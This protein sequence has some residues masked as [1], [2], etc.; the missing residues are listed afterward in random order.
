MPV[1]TV[2][3]TFEF[4]TPCRYCLLQLPQRSKRS[5]PVDFHKNCGHESVVFFKTR[6]G[7]IVQTIQLQSKNK[8]IVYG[9]CFNRTGRECVTHCFFACRLILS[10][11]TCSLRYLYWYTWYIWHL[12][13]K[14]KNKQNQT[15][16]HFHT[17]LRWFQVFTCCFSE[18]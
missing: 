9:F 16:S 17:L 11:N 10:I 18:P 1:A 2:T 5:L 8:E 15:N 6:N 14:I 13:S 3:I 7:K 12:P 4:V